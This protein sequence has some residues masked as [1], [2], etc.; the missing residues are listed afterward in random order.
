VRA[1]AIGR[2]VKK[3]LEEGQGSRGTVEHVFDRT[4]YLNF[5]DALV[6]VSAYPWRS[7]FTVNLATPEAD[8]SFKKL[9]RPLVDAKLLEDAIDIGGARVSLKGAEVY[10]GL[11]TPSG[12]RGGGDGLRSRLEAAAFAAGVIASGLRG[13]STRVLHSRLCRYLTAGSA[14]SEEAADSLIGLGEGFTPSGDDFYTGLSS[15]VAYMTRVPGSHAARAERA[16]RSL[17]AF[18]PSRARATTWASRK[19][20]EY[21]LVGYIDEAVERLLLSAVS[22]TPDEVLDSLLVL[23]RRG[24]DSGVYLAIGALAGLAAVTHPYN[25]GWGYRLCSFLV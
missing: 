17:R 12:L 21:A 19:Y 10:E 24:H 3:L 20:I 5:D 7:P 22:G 16:L 18:L 1:S 25:L 4:I 6:L 15:A 8:L 23:A 13:A 2:M 11:Q 14:I 9:V